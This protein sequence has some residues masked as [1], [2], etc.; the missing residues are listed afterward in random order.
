MCRGSGDACSSRPLGVCVCVCVCEHMWECRKGYCHAS[1]VSH[2]SVQP[3]SSAL[4]LFGSSFIM[5]AAHIDFASQ[6]EN[7]VWRVKTHCCV[8][9][10]QQSTDNVIFIVVSYSATF[11]NWAPVLYILENKLGATCHQKVWLSIPF[12]RKQG[13]AQSLS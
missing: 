7:T 9:S 3:C 12:I 13:N 10:S 5:W 4:M 2:W 6:S 11:K 1:V 8:V